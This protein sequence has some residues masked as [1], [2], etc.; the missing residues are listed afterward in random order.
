MKQLYL[1][2][3]AKS[4]WNDPSVEDFDRPLSK[5]GARAVA[6]LV[7][8]FRHHRIRPDLVLCSPARRARQTI[9]PLLPPPS[10]VPITFEPRLYEAA[11]TTLRALLTDLPQSCR[12]V[13]VVGHN[14]GLQRL[15]L[16]LAIPGKA[17]SMLTK[18]AEKFPTGGLVTLSAPID[19][20]SELAPDTC[21]LKGFVRP[22]DLA[23]D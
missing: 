8:Y 16:G 22:K 17:Q 20:W 7:K 2:R 19:D 5:R 6:I 14:P 3:H 11:P 1:L 9:E 12:S 18:L 13:L 10:D 4:S 15:A 23:P 21:T